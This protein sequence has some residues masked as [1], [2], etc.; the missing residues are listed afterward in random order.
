MQGRHELDF[1]TSIGYKLNKA[2]VKIS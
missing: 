1:K 2:S